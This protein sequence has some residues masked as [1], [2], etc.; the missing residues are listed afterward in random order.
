MAQDQRGRAAFVVAQK[1][2]HV[3]AAQAGRQHTNKALP[4]VRDWIGHV[5]VGQRFNT[6]VNKSLHFAVNPPSTIS[7]WPVT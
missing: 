6:G 5:L 4:L 1:G 3:R 2:V 7:T